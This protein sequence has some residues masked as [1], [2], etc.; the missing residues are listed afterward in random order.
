VAGA[1]LA[2]IG[3]CN[4][5]G[6]VAVASARQ[7]L[8]PDALLGRV[9]TAFRLFSLGASGAGAIAGGL[10]ADQLGLPAPLFVAAGLLF[11]TG[12]GTIGQ[13]TAE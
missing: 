13:R 10:V 1:T 2:L 9:F 8:T 12:L 3:G 7:V 5:L 4:S 11:V 6:S